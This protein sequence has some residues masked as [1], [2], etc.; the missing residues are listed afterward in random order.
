MT[1]F[2]SS[3]LKLCFRK[4]LYVNQGHIFGLFLKNKDEFKEDLIKIRK[5][6]EEF[7]FFT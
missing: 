3:G 5:N 4:F 2:L 1:T 6:G 7:F